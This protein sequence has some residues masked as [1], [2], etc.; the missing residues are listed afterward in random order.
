MDDDAF[1]LLLKSGLQNLVLLWVAASALQ[2]RSPGH[3]LFESAAQLS[4]GCVFLI[5]VFVALRLCTLIAALSGSP[6]LASSRLLGFRTFLHRAGLFVLVV[7][8]DPRLPFLADVASYGHAGMLL[9]TP[10][11]QWVKIARAGTLAASR[12]AGVPLPVTA[13]L[14][15]LAALY[16]NLCTCATCAPRHAPAAAAQAPASKWPFAS[17]LSPQ[18]VRA[19]E[20]TLPPLTQAGRRAHYGSLVNVSYASTHDG[21]TIFVSFPHLLAPS[22]HGVPF[23]FAER[24]DVRIAGIDAAELK[25]RCSAERGAFRCLSLLRNESFSSLFLSPV[26]AFPADA[27]C[28]SG[29]GARSGTCARCRWTREGACAARSDMG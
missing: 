5:V 19:A 24:I 21:D 18:S 10:D 27:R 8:S 29:G 4:H 20:R 11:W 28:R 6:A 25:A 22:H 14:F 12:A 3:K 26:S 15:G 7:S 1:E 9:L 16:T 17:S 23:L 2:W 13:S